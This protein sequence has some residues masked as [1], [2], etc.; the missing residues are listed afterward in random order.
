MRKVLGSLPLSLLEVKNGGHCPHRLLVAVRSCGSCSGSIAGF[1]GTS[2]FNGQSVFHCAHDEPESSNL[3]QWQLLSP[4]SLWLKLVLEGTLPLP[5]VLLVGRP[6]L[7]LALR[8]TVSGHLA[9]PTDVELSKLLFNHR[10]RRIVTLIVGTGIFFLFHHIPIGII[11]PGH[12]QD[13]E[14]FFYRVCGKLLDCKPV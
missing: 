3:Q 4:S 14:L 11:V 7:L 13:R 5:T 10:T 1:F 12:I 9:T 8:A 2:R 6:V